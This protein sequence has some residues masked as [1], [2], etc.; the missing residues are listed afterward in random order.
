M[1]MTAEAVQEYQQQLARG[2]EICFGFRRQIK[3]AEVSAKVRVL[4]ISD[5]GNLVT[6]EV[7]EIWQ[8]HTPPGYL[9]TGQQFGTSTAYLAPLPPTE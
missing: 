7:V 9:A 4:T 5:S 3:G 6:V 1:V 8:D 2:V